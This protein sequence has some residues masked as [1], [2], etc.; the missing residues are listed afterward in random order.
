MK[1]L[2][3]LALVAALGAG[4]IAVAGGWIHQPEKKDTPAAPAKPADQPK[5][6]KPAAKPAPAA[7]D[8]KVGERYVLGFKMKGIDGKDVDLASFKGKVVLFVN[9]ASQC[10]LTPQYEGLQKL[11]DQKKDKGLVIL[12]FP[13]NNFGAQEPGSEEEIEKFCKTKYKV[14]FPMFAKISVKGKDIDPLYKK[15]AATGGGEPSWNFTKYLVDRDGNMV[16][17]FDPKVK[18]DD[19]ELVK[20]IDE[21]LAKSDSPGNGS[22]AAGN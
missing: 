11:Y 13:A 18:P 6:S 1:T 22:A 9:V 17:R 12:G 8:A 4:V 7:P 15:L 16:K 14:T 10:G 3:P 20:K 19:S 2:I 5:D 21:L